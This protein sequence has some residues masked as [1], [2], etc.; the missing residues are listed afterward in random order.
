MSGGRYEYVYS[1]IEQLEHEIS[2]QQKCARRAAFAKLMGL[3][4]KAMHDIEWVDS[5]DYA[6]GDE[7]GAID[8]VFAF[9]KADPETIKKAHAFDQLKAR[10]KEFLK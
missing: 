7:H 5:C 3:V 6:P 4:G 2:D 9:L 10:L 8:R 1:R